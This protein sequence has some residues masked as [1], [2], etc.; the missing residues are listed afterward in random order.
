VTVA[1]NTSRNQYSAT[2]GQTVFAYTFEIVDK[3]HIVVLKNGVALSEGTNYSV[4][5]VGNDSGGNVTLTVGATTGDVLTLYRD[6]P[7]SRTQNYTNSGDFLASEVNS[8]F[9]D[10]WLAGEQTDRSFSQSIRKPI[11]DSD[12]I[13]MELPEAATRA[14]KFIKFD[15]N[16]AVD[17]AAGVTTDVDA[18]DVSIED[19]GGY[20]TSDNVEGALQEIGAQPP[21]FDPNTDSFNIGSDAVSSGTDSIALGHDA[22]A[23]AARDIALG[24]DAVASGGGS[25]AIGQETDSTGVRSI[26][27]GKGAQSTLST[28]IAIGEDASTLNG[29]GGGPVAIGYSALSTGISGIS[30]G[31]NATASGSRSI[32]IGDTAEASGNNSIAFGYVAQ[33]SGSDSIA[34]GRLLTIPG[35][36]GIAIGYAAA[37]NLNDGV[38]IGNNARV[39]SSQFGVAIGR[40]SLADNGSY[41]TA[42][43][44]SSQ[45]TAQSSTALGH[46]AQATATDSI[47]IG[48]D[49]S[50]YNL[51]AIA[52]GADSDAARIGSIALGKDAQAKGAGSTI[53]IGHSATTFNG[54]ESPIAIGFQANTTGAYGVGLGYQTVTSGA[55]GIAIGYIASATATDSIAI[56]RQLTT[57]GANAIGIGHGAE[58][59]NE[60]A[61]AIGR[62]AATGNVGST[63]IGY[64][65]TSDVN[66]I[67]GVAIGYGATANQ[68]ASVAI[69]NNATS[70]SQFGTAL[71]R[72]SNAD[73]GSYA[74]ALGYSS[75]AAT[76]ATAVGGNAD[77][78]G[79]N[80]T[81]VGYGSNASSN[82]TVALGNSAQALN[83]Q[84]ISIGQNASSGGSNNIA[85]GN[86]PTT[87]GVS[88]IAI[89]TS[90]NSSGGTSISIGADSWARYEG[91][92]A[93][94]KSASAT[95]LGV[96]IAIGR[97]TASSGAYG[98]SM[99]EGAIASGAQTLAIGYE[100]EANNDNGIAIGRQLTVAGQKAI[101][102]GW[103]AV[104]GSPDSI[105]IGT[106]ANAPNTSSISIGN[107]SQALG[108]GG[109]AIGGG[110]TIGV[111]NTYGVAIGHAAQANDVGG[112]AIGNNAIVSNTGT[113]G[114][115]IGRD[116]L[117]DNGPYGTALGY[118][119]TAYFYAT[120]LGS[121]T[122]ATGNY[123]TAIGYGADSLGEDAIALG[124]FAGADA[125]NTI[126]INAS[127]VN[128][129]Q[130]QT[131]GHIVIETDDASLTYD[132]AWSL[133]G[134]ALSTDGLDV[135][136]DVTFGD[137]DKAIF[138][139]G[140]D[141]QIYHDGNNSFI[142]D[143]GTGS[144]V[145]Q[146]NG[147]FTVIQNSSGVANAR[148]D[149]AGAASIRYNG[150]EKLATTLTGVDVTGTV[151]S[152][153]I[154]HT[155]DTDTFVKFADNRI[156]QEI[157]GYRV[158]DFE[159]SS[160]KL[161]SNDSVF[162]QTGTTTKNRIKV[163]QNGDVQ[164]FE[165]TG[166]TPKFFWSAASERLGL[167]TNSPSRTLHV[168]GSATFESTTG[169]GAILF[170]PTDSVNRIYS[171]AGN[172]STTPLAIAFNMGSAEAVRITSNGSV[173]IGLTSNTSAN[174]KLQVTG[175]GITTSDNI[176]ALAS[177]N[178]RYFGVS[179]VDQEVTM[180]YLAASSSNN[181]L[182]VGGGT[183]LAEPASVVKF[184]T[185]T[186]GTKGGGNE[187]LRITEDGKVG[188][189][190]QAPK[191]ALDISS[192]TGSAP[193]P[194]LTLTNGYAALTTG[195][196]VGA[197]NFYTSDASGFGANNSAI[198]E[199]QAATSIGNNANLI[200]K[201]GAPASEGADAV[202]T[203]RITSNGSV[204]IGTDSP[205][206]LVE[207]VSVDPILTIRDS[208]FSQSATNAT[209]RLAESGGSGTLGNYWDINHTANAELRFVQDKDGFNNERL[210]ISSGGHLL[211]GKTAQ[212][213]TNTVGF[214]AKDD[215]LIVAT[216]DGSRS[217]IL[218]RKTS[219]GTI[220]E[221]RKDNVPV[222]TISAA[223][224]NVIYGNDTRGL[225]I[226]DTLIIPRDVDDTTADGQMNLGSGTSRFK[227]LF[228]SEG[229]YLGGAA[230]ANKLDHYEEG[231]FTPTFTG[232][233][234]SNF[235]Y[236]TQSGSYTK[237]GRLVF[238]TVNLTLSS[239]GTSAGS[240][241]LTNLPFIVG[242]NLVSTSVEAAPIFNFW[243]GVTSAIYNL[244]GNATQNQATVTINKIAS[245]LTDMNTPLSASDIDNDFQ[246]RM[247]LVYQ[248]A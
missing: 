157:G 167:G 68:M 248:A 32:S 74:T 87:T 208:E 7:Y 153:G 211:V 155:G 13:S 45:A 14:N 243:G 197:I 142:D 109:V 213:S 25:I 53:A 207:I 50:S 231:T 148:F 15:A 99:G 18:D 90:A 23:T 230:A 31:G 57:T 120:A 151:T 41:A 81:A 163:N 186:I 125:D 215:G 222:G 104:A 36:R 73:S 30:L 232:T 76:Y 191:T 233:T 173:G 136:G 137:N 88:S 71:G 60:N 206:T 237:V 216:T 27:I 178:S 221:F 225:K 238:V 145:L 219:D 56:G 214:E 138:G 84:A 77:A 95:G 171:R 111:A 234:T 86:A 96:P 188:I 115:A 218:N 28:S 17:L 16:G 175:S 196:R 116:S 135:T 118:N 108:G 169:N 202:E 34:I 110:A 236:G 21:G 247:S 12:S 35:D 91:S 193:G 147:A 51:G 204:G 94:G 180:M 128:T 134:G 55:Q 212:D 160:S 26:A 241:S 240:L 201:T 101:G 179:Q 143:T 39:Y 113:F 141:L 47:S 70:N 24:L 122:D 92:I 166:T 190:L 132:G 80:S 33:A 79:A 106:S 114:T 183:G 75:E 245:A 117:A 152:D 4:S 209:L 42:L 133:A 44:Y 3:S 103:G 181:T 220:A 40:D 9:D 112:I 62:L 177:K 146:S 102:I 129:N 2:S 37:V 82:G 43:G 242:D 63:V 6:M 131:A 97:D 89:G 59:N 66:N 164:F 139:A 194:E 187:R 123:S 49:A 65:A 121:N 217:L 203:M 100:A 22:S 159:T 227:N 149:S 126:H 182:I 226:E 93:V 10:L 38:A 224:T 176:T 61:I 195:D 54:S 184:H 185:G 130:P 170:V 20:Y 228:L 98:I 229:V 46:G 198:I 83:L 69:G 165:D 1:D 124:H 140:S 107:T 29:A 168:S 64:S 72:D 52:I 78:T 85:I 150:V 5:N 156:Y 11:T 105:G 246:V 172:A 127:G 161:N 235:T 119:S 58:A 154:V 174:S 189:N 144:L 205:D 210:R 223:S 200:F 192:G 67:N 48:N 162:I 239:K 8:D 19:A 199:A 158:L 244:T